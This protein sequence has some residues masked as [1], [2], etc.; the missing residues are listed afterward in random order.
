MLYIVSRLVFIANGPSVTPRGCTPLPAFKLLF[1]KSSHFGH[2]SPTAFLILFSQLLQFSRMP[3]NR[4][5][6]KTLNAD[7]NRQAPSFIDSHSFDHS[8]ENPPSY[9]HPPLPSSPPVSLGGSPYL[10]TCSVL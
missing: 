9:S 3:L 8:R 1:H 6:R 2:A 5:S 4:T 10:S 7:F